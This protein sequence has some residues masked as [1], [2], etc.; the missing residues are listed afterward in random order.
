MIIKE[1]MELA[2]AEFSLEVGKLA[3]QA[4]GSVVVRHGNTLVLATCCGAEEFDPEKP[5]FPLT[6]DYRENFYAAGRFPGGFFKREGRMTTK[7]TLVCRMID[8]PMRPMFTEGYLG[9]TQVQCMVMSSDGVH[10][11]DVAAM[12]GGAAAAY[13]SPVPFPQPLASVR[14]G[15]VNDELVAFPTAEQR[16]ESKLDLIIAGTREAI[17][18]VEAGADFV[19]EERMIDALEF[20]HEMIG[21]II[22]MIESM[23]KQMDI[24]KWEFAPPEV[25]GDLMAEIEAKA[26]ARILEAI[27]TKGKHAGDQALKA[28]KAEVLAPYKED[29]EHPE[30]AEKASKYFGAIKEKVFR[31][32]ILDERKR[33]D[34]RAFDEV[35]PIACEVS[36]LPAAHGSGLFT[37]GETQA[38]VSLTMGTNTDS[39]ILDSMHGESRSR[40]M[41]HYN[42]PPF[43]VGE[44]RPIRGPGRR[45]IGHGALAERAL[46]PVIPKDDDFPYTLRLVSEILESNGSSSMASV[47]GGCLALLDGGIE[48]SA[49]V[50]G[51]AM[52]LVMEGDKYAVLTDIQGA[53][54]HYGDMDFKVT[55]TE[56]GITAL[57]MDIKI[58]GLTRQIMGEALEQAR[59]GRLHILGIMNET[60][61]E[62]RKEYREH[63]PQIETMKIPVDK[64]R[65]VIGSGGKVIKSIIEKT[66]VKID[67]EDDGKCVIFS[68]QASGLKMA[69]GMIEELIAVPET[70]KSYR[71]KIKRI[72]DFGAFVEI[73]PG[74]EG[75]LHISE[76]ANYRVRNVTDELQEGEDIMV[77]VL[78]V[79]NNGRIKLS[80]K[81]L[82]EPQ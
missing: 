15:L 40:F 65:D 74:T 68:P 59:R 61:N 46:F 60:I 7:E 19:T 56:E 18:M 32:Y 67:I 27:C 76:I 1:S 55:G 16:E 38:L 47:C 25:D 13:L 63:V 29:E 45:E 10:A 81:A 44:V 51:V 21:K 23:A 64:I 71:G 57:Q 26:G 53:E 17:T 49:P 22:D 14:V 33:T 39:Q 11:A 9:E 30:R 3:K 72:V 58:K 62:P 5:F 42:F 54:D 12:I 4:H 37:R 34:G 8:R 28:V 43:S 70:G 79:E 6:V 69:K 31:N 66:G 35:R 36:Y 82:L 78:A 73:L 20:G 52:G 2:G 75:L 41:L 77:K 50:A 48:I 80:R 24:Q